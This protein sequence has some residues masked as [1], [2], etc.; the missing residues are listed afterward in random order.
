MRLKDKVAVITGGGSGIGRAASLLF[1]SEGARVVVVDYRGVYGR[2][3]GQEVAEEVRASGG[4]ALYVEADLS[5]EEQVMGVFTRAAE[6]FG[7]VDVLF[8]NAGHGYSSPLAMGSFLDAPERD[9][10]EVI[11]NN[12]NSVFLCSR[13]CRPLME[14]RGGGSIINTASANALVAVPGAD[15]YT[16]AKGGV[17]SLT[18]V[19]A[20]T[21][22]PRIRVNCI[23]PGV[24]RTPMV[25]SM[26]DVLE[27][28]MVQQIPLKRVAEPEEIAR[29]ALFLASDESSYVTG[30]VIPVDGGWTAM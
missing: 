7:G 5:V 3:V 19:M 17:V 15:A 2:P 20:I 10:N 28:Y 24:V 27:D 4:E 8:N 12:L 11:R 1:A 21:L 26:L 9:W 25:K 14:E 30:A 29:V 16:A 23:C 13:H 6:E 18:R 22:A